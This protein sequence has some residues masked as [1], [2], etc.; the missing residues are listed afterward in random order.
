[1]LVCRSNKIQ[2]QPGRHP[3]GGQPGEGGYRQASADAKLPRL[4]Q[5]LPQRR[6]QMM[7]ATS[8]MER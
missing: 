5:Q 8:A 1:M 7:L 2:V 4:Q 3:R 6:T